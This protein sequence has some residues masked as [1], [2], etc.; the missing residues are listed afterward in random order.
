MQGTV[1]AETEAF[2]I[3]QR[4]Q[5]LQQRQDLLSQQQGLQQQLNELDEMLRKFDVFEGKSAPPRQQTRSRR[6]S[7]TRRGSK[8][9]ELLKVIREGN[10]LSRGEILQKMGLKGDKSGEMSVSNGL[11]ALT[12]ANQVIRRDGK[13]VAA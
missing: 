10:G 2:I 3:R 8:R 4:E 13:Y 6:A 9:D 12:K 5:L 1:L 11:T 7:G